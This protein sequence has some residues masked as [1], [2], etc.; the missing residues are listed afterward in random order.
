M[1][2]RHIADNISKL[3]DRVRLSAEKYHRGNSD[4]LV[5]AVSKT[6]SPQDIRAAHA[7]GL[8]QFGEN[9]VQE[10]VEKITELGDLD[11]VW[12]YIGPIQ[13]NK[14]RDIAENFDWVHSL[15]RLKIAR[16]LNDQRP[17]GLP[18]LQVCIQVNISGEESKSGLDLA[19]VPALA[20][21]L[22]GL[23]RLALRGLM[24]VPAAGADAPT[25]HGD[26][27]RLRQALDDLKTV[28]PGADTLSMGMSG[29][30]EI[31]IAEGAT[32]VRIG[33]AIFGPRER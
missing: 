14:T 2:E 21:E 25:L 6:R 27:A 29:D 1:N 8:R 18:P 31:A 22:A 33:T 3:L 12:H 28:A 10:A 20:D 15:D 9:Y 5:L 7:A 30:L 4:I 32:V 19:E 17:P 13:S 23:P 16:R 11:L 26:F 24:A